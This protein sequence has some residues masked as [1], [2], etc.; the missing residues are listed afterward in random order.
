MDTVRAEW[1]SI[2]LTHNLLKLFRSGWAPAIA[3]KAPLRPSGREN[4]PPPL[5]KATAASRGRML[6]DIQVTEHVL[7][8]EE[9]GARRSQSPA[10]G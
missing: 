4:P 3:W 10:G 7:T 9:I 2:C 6:D 5:L 8:T 1:K